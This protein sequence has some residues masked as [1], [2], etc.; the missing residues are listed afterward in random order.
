MNW[1]H[2]KNG[3]ARNPIYSTLVDFPS[4]ERVFRQIESMDDPRLARSQAEMVAAFQ[5]IQ[6]RC[7]VPAVVGVAAEPTTEWRRLSPAELV[8]FSQEAFADVCRFVAAAMICY[9]TV[10]SFR[11]LNEEE[12]EQG[13]TLRELLK[14][15]QEW[16][17]AN[18]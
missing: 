3:E 16:I 2:H 11:S 14:S 1:A 8:A 9:Q 18:Q 17:P 15:V 6:Q 4:I 7:L 5:P 10:R 12:Q 13:R